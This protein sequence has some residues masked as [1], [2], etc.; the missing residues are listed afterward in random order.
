MSNIKY[1]ISNVV[2]GGTII[3]AML[4]AC[5]TPPEPGAT[6]GPVFT[7]TP[8]LTPTPTPYKPD[9]VLCTSSSLDV[10]SLSTSALGRAI[11]W[12]IWPQAARYGEDY[13]AELGDLLTVLPNEADGTLR[14]NED[15]TLTVILR[16]RA[17]LVWSDGEPFKIADALQ[18]L[19]LPAL[20]A[21]PAFEVLDVQEDDAVTLVVT[22]AA[23]AE[24]PYVPSHPPLP[25]HFA[26]AERSPQAA[27]YGLYAYL[28]SPTLGPY[29]VAEQ[30]GESVVL[31]ANPHYTPAPSIPVVRFRLVADPAQLLA[32]LGS[33]GCDV[34]L[35][36]SLSLEQLPAWAAA[37]ASGAVRGY[38]WPGPVWDYLALNTYPGAFG[39]TP[40]FAD[41]RVRQAVAYA[42]DR[43]ALAQQ[44]WQGTASASD[45]WLPPDHWAYS[46]SVPLGID[47]N[48][49][50]SLLEQAGWI[51]QD[52]DG[53]RE[54]HGVGGVY[55]C[56]RG[57]WSIDEGIPLAPVLLT[58]S[59]ALR[60]PIAEKLR[61]DLAQIGMRVELRS[62]DPAALF[63]FGGPIEH[64]SFDM[65][66]LAAAVHPDPG[67]IN[68]WL[69]EDV[70]LH[71]L[72]K[73]PAH[74]WQLEARWLKPDQMIERLAPGNVP[75]VK[76]DYR[77]QNYSG[78]CN[79]PAD[80][81]IVQANHSF[82]IPTRQG[83]YAQQQAL[84]A[85]DLPA[86]P[87]FDRP[88]FAAAAP[89]VCGLQPVSYEPLTWNLGAWYF[90]GSGACG[91]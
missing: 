23:G 14:R 19:M 90:D 41:L 75:G 60:A 17:D 10:A 65:A 91:G 6:A 80:L 70:F 45:G 89:Y 68:L 88:R 20:P 15:G 31:H 11:G 62:T 3:V 69:G 77:G 85:V 81:A 66:L 29:V 33:G 67:G 5:G 8:A 35:D 79:D 37:Q 26:G 86:V 28:S 36:D 9:L 76:N 2:L 74:R 52:G 73:T 63:A 84:F 25:T 56:E 59:D 83:F 78:W 57:E 34:A 18:G 71:P 32:E 46:P 39:R 50:A 58:T 13:T 48:Q 61:A 30:T 38:S 82:D 7:E 64:R 1:H 22:L 47:R 4:T 40:Y 87:L 49:A 27:S 24:Y 16:Y 42:F 43:A 44:L 21:D 12:A 55:S 54:Y 72:E 53:V 51:D